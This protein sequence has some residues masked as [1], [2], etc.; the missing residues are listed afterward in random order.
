MVKVLLMKVD[1][2]ERENG[3]NCGFSPKIWGKNW[4]NFPHA[5][6]FYIDGES[7][8]FRA[9]IFIGGS[10]YVQSGVGYR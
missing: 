6:G 2:P 1:R 10:I 8:Y 4:R 3:R 7:I 5:A 9:F